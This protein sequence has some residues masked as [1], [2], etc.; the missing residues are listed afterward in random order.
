M[1]KFFNSENVENTENEAGNN[2]PLFHARQALAQKFLD[3][4]HLLNVSFGTNSIAM[5]PSGA[6]DIIRFSG[7]A[8]V[9]PVQAGDI[10][11]RSD[12]GRIKWFDDANSV[13]REV[14]LELGG[15]PIDAS[16]LN[17]GDTIVYNNGT[18]NWEF[19]A[20]GAA[21]VTL[22]DTI[23]SQGS[24]PINANETIEF[25][26]GN[27]TFA[28]D[29]GV[30]VLQVQTS[31]VGSSAVAVDSDLTLQAGTIESL[32][33][34]TI[35]N[36]ASTTGDMTIDSAGGI[37]IQSNGGSLTSNNIVVQ[38]L[39]GGDVTLGGDAIS[40][41]SFSG[42]ISLT[43]TA[44][45]HVVTTLSGTG[46]AQF[47]M[48]ASEFTISENAG[49]VELFAVNDPISMLAGGQLDIRADAGTLNLSADSDQDINISPEGSGDLNVTT[50]NGGSILFDTSAGSG[51]VVVDTDGANTLTLASTTVTASNG[52]NIS[53]TTGNVGLETVAAASVL[54]LG[55]PGV[56]G[57]S[58]DIVSEDV[59]I[60]SSASPLVV[61]AP[62]VVNSTGGLSL[63]MNP[64]GISSDIAGV[65]PIEMS[66]PAASLRLAAGDDVRLEANAGDVS[67]SDGNKG[68]NYSG[69]LPLSSAGSEWITFVNLYG[70]GTSLVEAINQASFSS[71]LDPKASCRVAS[72]DTLDAM[73]GETWTYNGAG[74]TILSDTAS[75]TTIDGFAL[76]DGD[77][78]L[79]KD[80][81][82]AIENGIYVVATG[83]AAIGAQTELTRAEDF[84]G[85]PSAEVSGGAF[86]FI[87][88]GTINASTGWVLAGD[89]EQTVNVDNLIWNQFS[90][91]GT[92][93]AGVG[94]TITGSSIAVDQSF[95]PTWTGSHTFDASTT[96]VY[97]G[98]VDFNG[99]TVF[100]ES[101][102]GDQS[103]TGLGNGIGVSSA[104]VPSTDNSQ[105][106]GYRD[107]V[108]DLRWSEIHGVTIVSG[109]HVFEHPEGPEHGHWRMTEHRD[110][111][112]MINENTG[113]RFK[114]AM[115]PL[116]D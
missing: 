10:T 32:S 36:A 28:D 59:E 14:G 62:G 22:Q 72:T 35:G 44:N 53:A 110:Y 84:D 67:F 12:T 108:N 103:F 82:S 23:T 20:P 76:A 18:G 8:A 50:G 46:E 34:F 51:S 38:T 61:S 90:G 55:N 80:Q 24:T 95:S 107:G 39:A 30:A 70:D 9:D 2:D 21:G 47:V 100:T 92:F 116:D 77:R 43:P 83:T 112:I 13:V 40:V 89:G 114:L 56:S 99:T 17:N 58:V 27:F 54:S 101:I 64:T 11:V 5:S 86:T 1:F 93:T 79:I 49:T 73:T 69:N 31:T 41:S 4:V 74:G 106:L 37:T 105:V 78:V 65:F 102:E 96:T 60:T 63:A 48:P 57:A 113:K 66:D 85:S 25:A 115:E 3:G 45:Q 16:N 7:T 81:S 97:D 68:G 87:E 111:M 52:L 109:D 6:G 98:S 71:G 42:D 91:A 19:V 94:I 88:I 29:N 15:A 26:D 104:M 33:D 75:V